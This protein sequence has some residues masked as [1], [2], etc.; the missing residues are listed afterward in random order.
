MLSLDPT[1]LA[2]MSVP[3]GTGWLLGACMEARGKQD[4]WIRQK[5]EVLEVLREQAIIQSV[6]SSNRIEGIT[7]AAHRLRPLVIGHARP[8]DR[9]EEELAGYRAA[10]DWIFS[11]KNRVAII[12][13]VIRRLHALAQGGSSGDAGEWKKRDNEI[14]EV[15]PSGERAVRF[16]PVSAKKTPVAI[17]EL[18]RVYRYLSDEGR[19]PALLIVATFVLDLLCIHPFRDGNGRVSRLATSLLLQSHGFDVARYISL[20]RLIE[21][22]KEE[23][24]RVLKLCSQGWHEGKNEIIP[25]WTYFLSVLRNAYREFERQVES[26]EARPAKTDLVRRTVLERLEP[27][28]L[29]DMVA[30]VPAAS[31]QLVKKVLSEMKK[32]GQVRLAGRGRGARW[33]VIR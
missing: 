16:V 22:S 31:P 4:L 23:Y 11:R 33:E 9:S 28:T 30:L 26:V 6:E 5:P 2:E 24:Y 13:S 7:V 15:L 27:F 3:I 14:I 25:W 29:A 8:R 10:L 19:V 20:E 21:E 18:C 17:D 1:K 12:P 32:A